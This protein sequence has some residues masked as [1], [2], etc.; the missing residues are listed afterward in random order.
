[1]DCNYDTELNHNT[2]VLKM[3]TV[4]HYCL[5]FCSDID[6][7]FKVTLKWEVRQISGQ[8]P[9]TSGP[10]DWPKYNPQM[11]YY[12]KKHR[13][14]SMRATIL[15][16]SIILTKAHRAIIKQYVHIQTRGKYCNKNIPNPQYF[17]LLTSGG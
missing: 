16:K 6:L 12:Y 14:G 15:P 5:N 17:P 11:A 13:G 9:L 2:H 3:T 4:E 8:M 10:C 1:M 7:D